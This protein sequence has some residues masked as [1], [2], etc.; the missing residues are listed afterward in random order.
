MRYSAI[1]IFLFLLC[2]SAE[3]QQNLAGQWETWIMG[4]RLEANIS[5][6]GKVVGG[7]AY[8]FAPDGKKVTYHFNGYFQNGKLQVFHSDG[9]SFSGKLLNSRKIAGTLTASSG[10]RLNIT[11]S[12]R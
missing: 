8:I 2:F 11:L 1:I 10:R 6:N 12:R 9:H 7:V 3:A 4:H 5:Q